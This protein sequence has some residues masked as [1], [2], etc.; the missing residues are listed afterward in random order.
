MIE[1]INS[2]FKERFG[3]SVAETKLHSHSESEWKQ[4]SESNGFNADGAYL[5]RG[6]EAHVNADSRFAAIDTFHEY[7]GHGLYTEHSVIGK[8]L[9][10]LEQK[11]MNEE[12]EAGVSSREELGRFRENSDTCRE[13]REF[14]EKTIAPYEGFAM[15]MEWHLSML[16]GKMPLYEKKEACRSEGARRLTNEFIE[17]SRQNTDYALLY[18]N[19]FPKHCNMAVLNEI[20]RNV[21][22]NDLNSIAFALVYGSRKPYSDIDLFIVSDKIPCFFTGWLD[23]Y[24]VPREKFSELLSKQDIS[25][26]DAL[27]SGELIYGNNASF[28]N[29]KHKAVSA[30]PSKEAI[31]FHLNHACKAKELSEKCTDA[32]EKRSAARYAVS[33]RLNAIEMQRGRKPLT[34]NTLMERY[35]EQF[36]P[37]EKPY[38]E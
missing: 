34:L 26:T 24:S 27:C 21:F 5:V 28:Q 2:Y 38:I 12:K 36:R 10:S 3:V 19:G 25:I 8:K 35:P 7:F 30:P 20:A 22:R 6:R 29:A 11:L 14:Q 31:D 33:Y 32:R 9:Y 23:V 37:F 17:F 18:A 13:I 16:T 4:F 1:E 15:W